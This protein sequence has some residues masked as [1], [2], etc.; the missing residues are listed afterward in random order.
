MG[1]TLLIDYENVQ[2]INLSEI[3]GTDLQVSVLD[4][5]RFRGHEVKQYFEGV[6]HGRYGRQEEEIHQGVQA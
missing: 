2:G 6:G 4:L 3:E 5:P 1:K